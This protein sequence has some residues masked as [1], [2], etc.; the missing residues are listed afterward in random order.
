MIALLVGMAWAGGVEGLSELSDAQCVQQLLITMA[1]LSQAGPIEVGGVLLVPPAVGSRSAAETTEYLQTLQA[2]AV[3]PLLVASDMEGG[4]FNPLDQHQVLGAVPSAHDMGNLTEEEVHAWGLRTGRALGG[5]GVNLDL[6]PVLDV[7]GEEGHIGRFERS[8]SS[9]PDRVISRGGAFARGLR[10]AGVGAM[11]KHY[12]G[13]GRA[14]GNADRTRVESSVTPDGRVFHE[15]GPALSGVMMSHIVYEGTP[16]FL[17]EPLVTAAHAQGWVTITDDLYAGRQ[18]GEDVLVQAFLAGNEL[19]LISAPADWGEVPAMR[20][21]LA[22]V[23]TRPEHRE[24]L[25]QACGRVLEL[26]HSLGLIE[27]R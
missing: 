16:G 2:R 18:F 26:K 17:S 5:L 9:D 3:V 10:E 1:P 21:Q 22:E 20:E 7:A 15:V 11:G 25:R 27:E 12:P 24:R 6:A 23:A 13:Y 8:F 14:E 4:R 19:L